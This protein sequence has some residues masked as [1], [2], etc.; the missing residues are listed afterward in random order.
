[1]L[2][3]GNSVQT[4]AGGK[5]GRPRA[6]ARN[7]LPVCPRLRKDELIFVLCPLSFVF[8]RLSF[9]LCPLSFVL[10][11]LSFVLC[12]L[13]FVLCPL[14]FV[15]CRLSFVLCR[16]SFVCRPCA[17]TNEAKV[18]EV[19]DSEGASPGQSGYRRGPRT[20][21]LLTTALAVGSRPGGPGRATIGP[22]G[23]GRGQPVR[24]D[25]PGSRILPGAG[26]PP[27]PDTLALCPPTAG[28]AISFPCMATSLR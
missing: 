2:I 4:T 6:A 5:P 8:C 10:C 19:S 25:R 12:L 18:E 15:L 9:V 28:R 11:P 21:I 27:G 3:F 1:V 7:P 22:P 14:S 13:S 26:P 16:L 20:P 24:S 17:R 23:R